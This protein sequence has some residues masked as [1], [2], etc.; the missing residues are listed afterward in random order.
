[1]L[2]AALALTVVWLVAMIG[3]LA[4][5]HS[6]ATAEKVAQYLRTEDLSRLSADARAKALRDFAWQM[7]ALNLEER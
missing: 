1:M 7:N 2:Y 4:A 3:F 5:G 6:K